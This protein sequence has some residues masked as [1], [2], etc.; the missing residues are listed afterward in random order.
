MDGA[1]MGERKS[2]HRVL[3]GKPNIRKHLE[4]PWLRWENNIKMDFL[5]IG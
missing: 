4:R 1:C 5:G 3:V 2:L